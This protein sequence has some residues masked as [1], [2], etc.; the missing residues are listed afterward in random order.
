[1]FKKRKLILLL[2]VFIPVQLFSQTNLSIGGIYQFGDDL[3]KENTG[4]I[5][6]VPTTDY[7]ACYQHEDGTGKMVLTYFLTFELTFNL[8]R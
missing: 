8:K 3:N 1:L 4:E 7:K 5:R 6:I 2:L